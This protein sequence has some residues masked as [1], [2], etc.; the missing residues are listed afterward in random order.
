MMDASSPMTDMTALLTSGAGTQLD[1]STL[2]DHSSAILSQPSSI[3]A[4]DGFSDAEVSMAGEENWTR[5]PANWLDAMPSDRYD[6]AVAEENAIAA[7]NSDDNG[8]YRLFRTI[9][10]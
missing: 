3:S 2:D 4:Y 8:L 1:S 6:D 7:V 10:P 9:S 5:V